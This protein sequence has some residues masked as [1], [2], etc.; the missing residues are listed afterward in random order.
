M[1]NI[2]S[3]FAAK[4]LALGQSVSA[5]EKLEAM[6]FLNISRPTFDKYISGDLDKI[7]KVDTATELIQFLSEKV[8]NRIEKIRETNLV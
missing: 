2:K 1:D 7:A 8:K 4:L 6:D 3:Q 5:E